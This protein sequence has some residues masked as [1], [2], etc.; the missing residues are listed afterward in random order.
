MFLKNAMAGFLAVFFA[1]P[2]SAQEAVSPG[3]FLDRA[4]GRT[5]TFTNPATG[6][7]VG[8][9]QFLR[10]DRSVWATDSGRCTY[11]TIE[12]RDAYICYIYEDAPDPENCWLAY[13]DDNE[14]IVVS[15][16]TGEIQAVTGFS[17]APVICEDKPVS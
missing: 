10:R 6:R 7:R 1:V 11:G 16:K 17:D 8:V 2:G 4:V 3:A 14:L 12:I 15:G 13:M 5:L 9:E